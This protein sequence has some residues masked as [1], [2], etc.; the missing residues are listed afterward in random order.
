MCSSDLEVDGSSRD[1]HGALIDAKLLARVYLLMTGGQVGFFSKDEKNEISIDSAAER[2]DYS[3][4]KVI[5][6]V[7]SKE[8]KKSHKAYLDKLSKASNKK[9]NW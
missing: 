5:H 6:V 9:L 4:R 1:L 7:A 3:E 2:F 8:Q